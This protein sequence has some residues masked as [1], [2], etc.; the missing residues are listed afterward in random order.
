[1]ISQHLPALQVV[2]PLIAAP[3]CVLLRR[4]AWAWALA[5]VASASTLA[6]ALVLLARVQESGTITYDLGGWPAP[7]GIEY[8]IDLVNAFVLVI[9]SMISTI[10]LLYG[11]RSVASEVP[12]EK[13]HL[14]YTGWMLFLTGLLGIA[15]TGDAFNVFVFLEISSLSTYL[16][17]SL[18]R[19]RRALMAAFRYLIMGTIGATF[20]LIG[21]GLLYMMTGTLNL[22]DI[23]ERLPA[24][25]ETR[26]A[27]VAFAFVLI[28][29]GIKA[30]VFPLHV[31]LPGAYTY[32]PSAVSVVVAATSTKVAV[33]L[34]M[35]FVFTIFGAQYVF[36]GL[37]ID[38]L[39]LLLALLAM[40]I[41]STIAIFQVNIKRMLAWS[42]IA[43]IG[44]MVL[45][46]SLLSQAA[47]TAS[48]VHLFNHAI[49]K[50]ALFMVMG[51]VFFRIG[52]VRLEDMAGLGREMPWT[53]AA[54]VVAGL[55]LVGVPL[56]V[57]F[58]SKWYLVLAALQGGHV[59]IAVLV[60]LSSLLAL[61]YVWRVVEVAYFRER[62]GGEAVREAP[63]SLLLPMWL[64][65][66]ASI[67]FGL[68]TALT[69]DVADAAA[70]TLQGG[71][72]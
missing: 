33:Y 71:P 15:I 13:L 59:I 64:L 1:V 72:L 62:G 66:A 30:A 40:F 8:R 68:N 50:A 52:S 47:L 24:A 39:L 12:G 2:V 56:T 43:Q 26:T 42:S 18:G 25:I 16:L 61:I 17:I 63:L 44:Y 35:R 27:K 70:A 48:I 34:I 67:Y 45:G 38:R 41:A 53:M 54:F 60:L 29:L 55:S 11:R 23:A 21:I 19:D 49:M 57:G 5:S 58:V 22:A 46:I 32:A 10:T 28:G 3:V 14:F 37:G 69:V 20:L 4:G 36:V 9:V 65:V 31:W 51:A 6:A 7:Y